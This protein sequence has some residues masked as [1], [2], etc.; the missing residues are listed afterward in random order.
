LF[1]NRGVGFTENISSNEWGNIDSGDA[2]WSINEIRQADSYVALGQISVKTPAIEGYDFV[3]SVF[4]VSASKLNGLY[5]PVTRLPGTPFGYAF[6][7][8]GGFGYL[9]ANGTNAIFHDGVDWMIRHDGLLWTNTSNSKIGKWYV[10]GVGA[11]GSTT[12]YTRRV[13]SGTNIW[14][15]FRQYQSLPVDTHIYPSMIEPVLHYQ[16]GDSNWASTVATITGLVWDGTTETAET[17]T[18]TASQEYTSLAHVWSAV[19]NITAT[20]AVV[21]EGCSLTVVYTNPVTLYLSTDHPSA[22]PDY[23]IRKHVDEIWHVVDAL[24]HTREWGAWT[25]S[26]DNEG[27]FT[28]VVYSDYGYAVTQVWDDGSFASRDAMFDDWVDVDDDSG[29]GNWLNEIKINIDTDFSEPEWRPDPSDC[30]EQ[31]LFQ[32]GTV[33]PT[34]TAQPYHSVTAIRTIYDDLLAYW[35]DNYVD[36]YGADGY[37]MGDDVWYYPT[38]QTHPSAGVFLGLSKDTFVCTSTQLYAS[39]VFDYYADFE[40][41]SDYL[42]SA[43]TWK[44]ER[45]YTAHVQTYIS[46]LTNNSGYVREPYIL[47][48]NEMVAAEARHTTSERFGDTTNYYST[49]LPA[50]GGTIEEEDWQGGANPSA[51]TNHYNEESGGTRGRYWVPYTN[52]VSDTNGYGGV[53]SSTNEILLTDNYDKPNDSL[54]SEA[55][56]GDWNV[57]EW[58]YAYNWIAGGGWDEYSY[59][60]TWQQTRGRTNTHNAKL[61]KLLII[62][63]DVD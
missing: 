13:S 54:I 49:V 62:Q 51:D 52:I 35:D 31:Q 44:N 4:G 56:G 10:D 26:Y 33:V 34:D 2:Y 6:S 25:N 29:P 14:R 40:Q 5:Y 3:G 28:N 37:W 12:G 8:A 63:W 46:R 41:T 45:P 27:F 7:G 59:Q 9:H 18:V 47:R 1:T 30:P 16:D 36:Y 17:A 60:Y 38:N 32:P 55:G 43:V 15:G 23:I 42:E 11:G 57:R 48:T 61:E 50:F 39:L 22:Q 58:Y 21:N 53:G 19:S 20:G 24:R